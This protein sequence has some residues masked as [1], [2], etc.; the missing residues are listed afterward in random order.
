MYM[1]EYFFSFKSAEAEATL[2][3][4]HSG[5]E[6]FGQF[7]IAMILGYVLP[8][9][10]AILSAKRDNKMVLKVAATATLIGLYMAKDVWLKIPQLLPLS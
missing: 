8:F 1:G 6:Y 7:W 10:M 5:G 9:F 3:Y 2:E 4:V